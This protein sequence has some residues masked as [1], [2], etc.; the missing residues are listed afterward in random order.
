[1][2]VIRKTGKICQLDIIFRRIRYFGLILDV[3]YDLDD[4]A[5]LNECT[6]D[7]KDGDEDGDAGAG[8]PPACLTR[9]DCLTALLA[10]ASL[11][12]LPALAE[13][14]VDSWLFA[15]PP[16]ARRGRLRH[17]RRQP[18]RRF[19]F[20][21]WLPSTPQSDA[22]GLLGI[23][24]RVVTGVAITGH[25]RSTWNFEKS[26][27]SVETRGASPSGEQVL[28]VT[29]HPYRDQRGFREPEEQARVHT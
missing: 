5:P 6:V 17:R 7:W 14:Q 24:E 15:R 18:C 16:A 4:G 27:R 12:A 1:M 22:R 21:F 11:L 26:A 10:A 8:P 25:R 28:C 29:A 20:T 2:F 13:E 23:V 19:A 9:L 3:L